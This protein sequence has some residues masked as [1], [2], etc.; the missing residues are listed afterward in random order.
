MGKEK[1][2]VCSNCGKELPEGATYC[3]ECG[4]PIEEPIVLKATKIEEKAGPRLKADGPFINFSGYVASLKSDTSCFLALLGALLTYLAPFMSWGWR[5][6]F[7]TKESGNLFDFGSKNATMT[8]GKSI[9][10]VF[11]IL[12][13]LNGVCMLV[14]SAREN[15]RPIRPHADNVILW[16]VPIVLGVLVFILIIRNETY[17]QLLNGIENQIDLAKHLGNAKNIDGGRGFGPIFY[18]GGLALYTLSVLVGFA[19]RKKK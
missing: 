18:L 7:E 5:R 2:M 9:F 1:K 11:A 3:L 14:I 4:E 13:V 6:L 12:V 16:L 8:L 15:I 17:R 10:L 19:G